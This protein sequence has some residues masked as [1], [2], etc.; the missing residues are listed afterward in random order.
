MPQTFTHEFDTPVYKGKTSFP[1][2]IFI[3]GEF[4]DGSDGGMIDV[5]NPADTSLIT[6]VSEATAKDVDTAVD[7]A[8]KAFE[9][10]WGLNAPGFKRAE[11]LNNLAALMVKH[12]D[13]L[14]AI[15]ALDN[16][17][18]YRW[19]Q[20]AD[21][22][23][24]I[25]VIKYYAG[26]ADKISGQVIETDEGRLTYTR[27][28]PI[29]V[30]GQIIPWN[31]PIL[32]MVMKLGPA[33]A[34][35]NTIVM[36]TSEFTPLSALRM[37]T[38]LQEAGFPPGVVNVLTGYG[39]T[40]GEAISH[41]MKIEKV[42]F[43]GSIATGHKILVAAG[44]SNLKKVT[45]ELGGKSPNII[46]NDADLEQAINWS[47]FGIYWNHGQ[48]CCAGSRVFVQSG[49]YDEFLAKFTEKSKG[50]KL[51]DP[52]GADSFQGPQVS[53][54][55]YNRLMHYIDLGKQQGATLHLGGSRHDSTG[56]FVEPT[57][58]T[59][60]SPDMDIVQEEIFGPISCIIKFED[61]ADIVRQAN[62]TFYGLAAAVF[63]RDVTRAID[64]A[65]RLKAGTVWVNCYN[66]IHANMPFGGFKKSGFGREF[67]E[68][69]LQNYTNVKSININLHHKMQ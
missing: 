18:T 53:E 25:D 8:Q 37:C 63:T 49:V 28:E 50:I 65:N 17:K 21:L 45:L 54:V 1:T 32:M 26:W 46:F 19:A 7:Y 6:Q 68:Y 12:R 58:F 67:S 52:F 35:G 38:L 22:P 60:T 48:A 29:G 10:T 27:H 42:A 14:C 3:N 40:V 44:K 47:F 11:L 30:V 56:Y 9:T 34:T 16:G 4:V 55:Q 24:S 33:L 41:H 15:E 31:F 51:G 69:A 23:L 36:K 57:I 20:N 59:N 64:T 62:D 13:E 43:T 2:G 39:T 5:L 61:E 66:A